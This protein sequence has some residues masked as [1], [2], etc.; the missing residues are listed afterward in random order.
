MDIQT[1]LIPIGGALIGYSTNWLAIKMLFR[2]YTEKR[3]LGMKVA[4]TPGLIPKERKRVASS[5]GEVIEDYLLTDHVILDE[6]SKESTK[7]HLLGF[8]NKNIYNEAGNIH[9]QRIFGSKENGPM[10]HKLEGLLTDKM[11]ELLQDEPTK[12]ML[13]KALVKQ[14]CE[15]LTAVKAK[16]IISEVSFN[17]KVQGLIRNES[18]QQVIQN[19]LAQVL[20]P[21]RTVS[22]MVDEDVIHHLKEVI[23]YHIEHMMDSVHVVFENEQVKDKVVDLIDGTIKEKVGALGAMFVNAES[24][25]QTIAEKSKEKLQEEDVRLGICQFVSQKIDYMLNK[26]IDDILPHDSRHQLMVALASYIP[27]AIT[28]MNLYEAINVW[29]KALYHLIDDAMDGQLEDKLYTALSTRYKTVLEDSQ[30]KDMLS[31]MVTEFLDKSLSSEIVINEVD[32]KQMDG[33]ILSKYGRFLENHMMTLIQ[34]VRLSKIIEKQLNSFDLK[35]L[36]DIILTIAKK[37]LSAITWL[38][39]VLGF[40]IGLFTLVF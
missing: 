12:S 33:F 14:I 21:D 19:Y 35:M 18:L 16:E 34:D 31:H 13:V 7:D 20:S 9:L 11:L 2:P 38:G 28:Q 24:I 22:D 27:Q 30:T 29:D 6:L 26:P 32:K 15:G 5:I 10:L 8:V 4:F 17:E 39:G 3:F 36:E 25:Y 37:E 1:I 40:L 23:L